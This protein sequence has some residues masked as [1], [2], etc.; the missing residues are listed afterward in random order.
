[1]ENIK[2]Y[3]LIAAALLIYIS[4]AL[5]M[6]YLKKKIGSAES[7]KHIIALPILLSFLTGI[8]LLIYVLMLK[9]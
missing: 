8:G 4:F 1:M 2:L 6:L 3:Y 9:N 5:G 7:M